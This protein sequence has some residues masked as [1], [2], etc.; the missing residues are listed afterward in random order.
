[1]A[2]ASL[3][4]DRY[5]EEELKTFLGRQVARRPWPAVNTVVSIA[6]AGL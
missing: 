3:D 6:E 4:G 1:M 2:F 5:T